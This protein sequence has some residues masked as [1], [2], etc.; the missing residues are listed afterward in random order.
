MAHRTQEQKDRYNKNRREERVRRRAAEKL[1]KERRE[2]KIQKQRERYWEKKQ[3]SQSAIGAVVNPWLSRVP[4]VKPRLALLSSTAE[5]MSGDL[6][7]MGA[8]LGAN[9]TSTVAQNLNDMFGQLAEEF[10]NQESLEEDYPADD[11]ADALPS[12]STT[13]L[14]TD[15]HPTSDSALVS[16]SETTTGSLGF[17]SVTAFATAPPTTNPFLRVD[18]AG[19]AQKS[20]PSAKF[21]RQRLNDD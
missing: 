18:F 10:R 16:F 15:S 19:A 1:S 6:T 7:N 12:A 17:D 21:K 8:T 20:A 14:L 4:H 2:K 5:K 3:G 11:V 9:I 13:L